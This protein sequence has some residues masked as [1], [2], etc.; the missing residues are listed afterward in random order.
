MSYKKNQ[1]KQKNIVETKR[2]MVSR[3]TKVSYPIKISLNEEQ[4]EAKRIILLNDIIVLFGKAGSGK[5]L[6]AAQCA[7]D[8]FR[9]KKTEQ[10]RITRPTVTDDEGLGFLPGDILQK[11]EPWLEPIYHNFYRCAEKEEIDKMRL[12]KA[13]EISPISFLRGI[14]FLNNFVIVDE[15]QNI[16]KEQMKKIITR[17]GFGSKI[18]FCG[19]MAQVDLKKK[20]HSGLQY[21]IEAG[22]NIPGFATFELKENHRNPIVD[23]FLDAFQILDETYLS[24][25][26]KKKI[27]DCI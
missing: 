25:K 11:M 26:E 24:E 12:E 16:T 10:I 7:L 27:Q 6:L 4:K 19:D 21:L 22:Q 20:F 2:T 18:V 14:T 13:I 8:S 5:T 3:K 9:N 1:A 23:K 15:C 17:I